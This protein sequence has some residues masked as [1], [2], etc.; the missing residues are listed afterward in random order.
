MTMKLTTPPGRKRETV[1]GWEPGGV[2]VF[3]KVFDP[4]GGVKFVWWEK[5]FR[6]KAGG[7]FE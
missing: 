3:R 7:V 5:V 4:P 1:G 6:G 2:R